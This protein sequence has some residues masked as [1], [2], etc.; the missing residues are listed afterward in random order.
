MRF[1]L[2]PTVGVHVPTAHQV[3]DSDYQAVGG[4]QHVFGAPAQELHW[5]IGG[6]AA[7]AAADRIRNDA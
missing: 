6:V 3:D 2:R 5:Q 1:G 4:A 7:G